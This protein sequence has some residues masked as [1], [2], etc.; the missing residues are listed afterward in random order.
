M[1]K[2][3]ATVENKQDE[4]V[5]V[6]E[7]G[8]E[9]EAETQQQDISETETTSQ[10]DLETE[11]ETESETDPETES[12]TESETDPETESETESETDPETESETE[13]ET[14]PETESETESETDPETESETES[15]TDP[16]TESETESETD[17]ETESETESETDPET[18]SERT[19]QIVM[20]YL[21]QP[22]EEQ[23]AQAVVF[24]ADTGEKQIESAV[25]SYTDPS[26]GQT[27]QAGAVEI[28][29]DYIAFLIE[30]PML[31]QEA[32]QTLSLSVEGDEI[33]CS[34]PEFINSQETVSSSFQEE[35]TVPAQSSIAAYST[36]ETGLVAQDASQIAS[37]LEASGAGVSTQENRAASNIVVVLDPGHGGWD[38][39]ATR[40]WNGVTY[41]EKEI[42]LKISLATKAELEKYQGVTVYL[43]R[44][45][46][47]YVGIKER[48]DYAVSVGA[49]V[50]VSQHINSTE[51]TQTTVS[52]A[53][54]YVSVGKYRPEVA[55]EAKALAE[56]ILEKLSSIG[57]KNLGF[58]TRQSDDGERYPNG[59]LTDYMG[60]VRYGI[61]AGLPSMIV[62][63]GFV[64]NPSD[65]EKYY[66]SDAKIEAL[67]IADAQAIAE[68]YGLKKINTGGIQPGFCM[69]NGKVRYY[70]ADLKMVTGW[71]Q[72]DGD[73]YYFNRYGT[74]LTGR[75]KL[76][77][78]LYHHFNANGT[79][80]SGWTT[81]NG[82]QYFMNSK[83][84]MQ[85]GW[86]KYGT[87]WYYLQSNGVM[88]VSQHIKYNGNYY[89]VNR[90]GRRVSGWLTLGTSK[91]YYDSDGVRQH[92]WTQIGNETYYFRVSNG[93]MVKSCWIQSNSCWFYIKSDGTMAKSESVY[94]GGKWY[95]FS[96]YGVCQNR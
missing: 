14:D 45:S 65:C 48:V 49:D 17:P 36:E 27:V 80:K 52:G 57:L 3:K 32:L 46:D 71:Y 5:W 38:G 24:Q 34:I 82:K 94:I 95:Q 77:D 61:L 70:T 59:E 96:A 29:E 19:A 30:G 85:F 73:W 37:I 44:D 9:I 12:E 74:M 72:I 10:S 81:I 87:K 7:S 84:V 31:E 83:G 63:H 22:A 33:F 15:E 6:Q 88:A 23:I 78:G 90:Y 79:A 75:W 69:V 41:M 76:P 54:V 56:E 40:T 53:L 51:Q 26:N 50:L 60:I 28:V 8:V 1:P 18:E 64:S 21:G 92:G 68:Y 55:N 25:L 4:S 42:A 13:S 39:G 47:V 35:G 20:M 43:T 11:S 91:L 62:E 58:L 66:G 67:G 2:E 86:L 89:Y 93:H 16:E